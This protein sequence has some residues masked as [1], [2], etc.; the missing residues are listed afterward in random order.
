MKNR[1]RII[2][3]TKIARLLSGVLV[4]FLPKGKRKRI[5][6]IPKK[7]F[8]QLWSLQKEKWNKIHE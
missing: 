2:Y 5:P 7:S 4:K 1:T 3:V 8:I 6:K